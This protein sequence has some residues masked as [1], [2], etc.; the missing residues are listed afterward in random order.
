MNLPDAP[1][2]SAPSDPGELLLATL[3]QAPKPMTLPQ[4]RKAVKWP[5]ERLNAALA[6]LQ[7]SG[8]IFAGGTAKSPAFW[9]RDPAV[10]ARDAILEHAKA[11]P[12]SEAALK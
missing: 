2:I 6:A 12:L 8:K 9:N 11:A 5:D 3:A 4:L 10:L 7:S 1:T